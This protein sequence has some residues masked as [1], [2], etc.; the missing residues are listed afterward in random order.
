[1]NYY[2]ETTFISELLEVS[3]RFCYTDSSPEI[4]V[5]GVYRRSCAPTAR[6]TCHDVIMHMDSENSQP[7]KPSGELQ[8][9]PAQLTCSQ[10]R[11]HHSLLEGFFSQ[12][13]KACAQ[14][15]SWAAYASFQ[16]S[17]VLCLF[18]KGLCTAQLEPCRHPSGPARERSRAGT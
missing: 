14:L 6:I 10:T 17:H 5:L 12:L 4:I 18:Q 3:P 16:T 11:A 9:V 15:N 8:E 2:R 7:E 1:M 13:P